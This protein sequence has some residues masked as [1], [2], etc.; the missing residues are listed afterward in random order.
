MLGDVEHGMRSKGR[1]AP[2]SAVSLL[3]FKVIYEGLTKLEKSCPVNGLTNLLILG[4]NT[5]TIKRFGSLFTV[6]VL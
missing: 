3:S 4:L 2:S 6:R 5:S 1:V